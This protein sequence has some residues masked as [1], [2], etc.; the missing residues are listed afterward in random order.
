MTIIGYS[1]IGL[2]LCGYDC[3]G[4]WRDLGNY[5]EP[6]SIYSRKGGYIWT[7]GDGTTRD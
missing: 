2:G 3:P 6:P 4:G 1:E 5:C 7:P